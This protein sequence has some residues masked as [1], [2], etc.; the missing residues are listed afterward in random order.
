MASSKHLMIGKIEVTNFPED[1]LVHS[2]SN[3]YI[4]NTVTLAWEAATGGGGAGSVEVTNFPADQLIHGKVEFSNYAVRLDT[5]GD[6]TYVGKGAIGANSALAVWRIMK[7]DE[8]IGMIMM[9]ADGNDNFD[10]VW[11]N[12]ESLVYS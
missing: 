3:N 11:D 12:R 1:R 7:L 9:Y 10:N 4:W 6:I 5:V 8:T 2:S